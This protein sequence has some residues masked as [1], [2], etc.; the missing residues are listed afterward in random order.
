MFFNSYA[1]VIFFVVVATLFFT[2]PHRYR[3][4]L[5]LLASYFYYMYWD[6]KYAVLILTTTV[7]VYF[8]AILMH[9]RTARVRK[10]LVA[11]S[12][13]SNLG[14]LFLF[15]YFDFFNQ[16][17]RSLLGLFGISYNVPSLK[18][19]IPESLGF[20]NPVVTDLY[21]LFGISYNEPA[22]TLL[23][24]VVG[25]SFYTFMALSYTIDVYRG[26]REPERNFGKFALY[27]SF[28]PVLLSGPIE[29][30]TSL[31]PQLY[32]EQR[33]DYDR[34]TDGLKL[35]AWG[36]FQKFV[37]ADR[38]GMYVNQVYGN[39]QAAAFDGLPLLAATYFFVI[40]VYCDFAGYTD[41]AI[42][43]AQVLGFKLTPNFK[44]PYFASTLGELWR[45]WHITLITWFRDYLYIP[46]GGNRVSRWRL[47][48]NM[49]IVFS[50]SGLWHGAQWTFVIW[51]SLN[52]VLLILGRMTKTM[53]DWTRNTVFAALLKVP[54]AAYF[55][56][57]AASV[58]VALIAV[59]GPA[60]SSGLPVSAAV[61]A[62]FMAGLGLL[63]IRKDL[64]ER[65]VV[66][67]KKL[68]MIFAT[69]HLFVLGA[70]FF[71]ANSV[72]DAWYI[73][74]NFPGTNVQAVLKSFDVVQLALMILLVFVIN[75]VHY[76]QETRGSIRDMIRAKPLWVRWT[77]YFLLCTSIALLG[78]RGS[79]QFIYFRF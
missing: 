41:V 19:L 13:L 77:C 57:C 45:R 16:S 39:P 63:G 69:F 29:R 68:W 51:G 72:A 27:V 15:K 12:L 61:V 38:L 79:Q 28:F 30:S 14:I 33:F 66:A 55:V 6:P 9:N 58:A 11:F 65:A 42:G 24:P 3:W 47:Y 43:T 73:L 54:A 60:R 44:R 7:I 74:K 53:R 23:L 75:I 35:I 1:F 56:L 50:L 2:L 64:Y 48:L 59:V 37:I 40:Q 49:I 22:L 34:I 4:A 18:V 26:T 10:L 8:S 21:A 71:R 46:L 78:V 17:V 32:Q 76:I 70:V 31:I 25:I 52:G 20:L 62:V 36:L 67:A 5:L